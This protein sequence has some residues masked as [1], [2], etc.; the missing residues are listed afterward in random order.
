MTPAIIPL[1][2]DAGVEAVH[3][4]KLL[5]QR[6]QST[7]ASHSPNGSVSPTSRYSIGTSAVTLDDRQVESDRLVSL[8]SS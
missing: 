4:G 3:E 2:N 8:S 5:R 7:M 6:N 1:A